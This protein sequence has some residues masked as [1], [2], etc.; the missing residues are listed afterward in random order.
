MESSIKPSNPI[1]GKRR[2]TEKV[3]SDHPI[4]S[5]N[6]SV[7]A[8]CPTF[9]LAKIIGIH[10]GICIHKLSPNLNKHNSSCPL[11]IFN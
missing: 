10:L 4:I 1:N 6:F 3:S 2:K 8:K 7:L 9:D 11:N 5:D